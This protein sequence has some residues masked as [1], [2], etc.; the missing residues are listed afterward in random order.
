M[1]FVLEPVY[2][3]WIIKTVVG[4]Q[5]WGAKIDSGSPLTIVGSRVLKSFGV[6]LKSAIEYPYIEYEGVTGDIGKAFQVPIPNFMLG[7]QTFGELTVY[8][9]FIVKEGKATLVNLNKFLV[10]TDFLSR[11]NL[12]MT[13]SKKLLGIERLLGFEEHGIELPKVVATAKPFVGEVGF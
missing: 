3:E 9:P 12:S 1:E 10:G 11:Y 5:S 7:V 2:R 13:H 6:E 4:G 8:V